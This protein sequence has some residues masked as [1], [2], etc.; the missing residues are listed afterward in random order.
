[1]ALLVF[2]TSEVLWGKSA[3]KSAAVISLKSVL[4]AQNLINEL[5]PHRTPKNTGSDL[6]LRQPFRHWVWGQK[7][8]P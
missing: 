2:G 7:S 5:Y 3:E 8:V 4:S 6:D 1:M